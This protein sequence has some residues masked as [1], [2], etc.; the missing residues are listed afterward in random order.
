MIS[1]DELTFMRHSI[2]LELRKILAYRVDFWAQALCSVIV[3]VG[4]AYFLW[5]SIFTFQSVDVIGGYSFEG[6]IFYYVVA[7]FLVQL[8]NGPRHGYI[9]EEIYQGRLTKFLLFP[10]SFILIKYSAHLALAL[11]YLLQLSVAVV[12]IL[13]IFGPPVDMAV[14]LSAF[15]MGVISAL[16]ASYLYYLMA[17]I[18]EFVAFW[19]DNV[20]G[21]SIMLHFINIFFGGAL[22]PL[23]LFPD[24][25]IPWL[26]LSP[27]A[28]TI[29]M[30]VKTFLGDFTFYQWLFNIA[31]ALLW[32]GFFFLLGRV[33]WRRGMYQYTGVGI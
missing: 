8:V 7:A 29:S 5:K 6:M 2:A 21:L 31:I 15:V 3:Q 27:F 16:V 22:L 24:M 9:A 30:P 18:V 28:A 19:A 10:I 20:W 32:C 14:S 17:N 23:S 33:V 1:I 4:V 11:L 25:I 13:I 26:E 12:A